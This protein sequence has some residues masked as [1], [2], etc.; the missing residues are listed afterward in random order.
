MADLFA[1]LRVTVRGLYRRP[2][3]TFTVLLTLALAIGANT[4]IFSLVN[5]LLIRSLPYPEASGL[6]TIYVRQTGGTVSDQRSGIDGQ[7]W[8][9]LRDNVPSLLSAVSGGMSDGVNVQMGGEARFLAGGRVSANYFNVLGIRPM[10]GRTFSQ[11]EDR[12]HG[13]N[14]ALLSY[15]VWHATFGGDPGVIGRPVLV[16]GEPYTVIGVLP[17]GAVTPLNAAVYT[18][19]RADRTG[20][21]QGTN[22]DA[23][24]RLKPHASWQEA[25]AE[26][27]RAWAP[28]RDRFSQTYPNATI[29]FHTVPLQQGQTAAVRPAALVLMTV[30][31]SI[32]LIACANL[33]GL[34]LVRVQQR[35]GEMATRMAL[36]A[37]RWQMQRQLWEENLLLALLGG[38]AGVG[39]GYLA[40]RGLLSMLPERFLPVTQVQLDW[41]VLAF[42]AVLALLTSV[43]FGMLPSLVLRRMDLRTAM[44]SRTLVSGGGLRLRQALIVGE[45]ALTFV[46]LAASGLLVRTLVHLETL[47]P[48]FNPQG[49]LSAKVSL[50]DARY[51][52]PAAFRLLLDQSLARMRQIPGVQSAAVALTLPYERALNDGVTLHDGKS[53]GQTVGTDEVYVTPG[54]FRTMQMNLLRGREFTEEDSPRSQPVVIVNQ[55]F[56]QKFFQ[57]EDAVGHTVSTRRIVGVVAD[58]LLSAGLTEGGAPLASEETIYVPAS[59]WTDA[60]L[61]AMVHVW[62]QPSWVVRTSDRSGTMPQQMEAALAGVDAN[63]PFSGF[64]SMPELMDK[65][66]AT[67]RIEVALLTV[68]A[69]LALLLSTIGI[70]ALVANVIAQRN[71]EIGIRLALGSTVGRVMLHVSRAGLVP[72]V[73]G[74][75]AGL[76]LCGL[77]LRAIRSAL[78]GVGAFDPAT[79]A[80]VVAL[81]LAVSACATAVPA[82]RAAKVDP[83]QTLREE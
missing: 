44:A 15:D 32:L 28:L 10:L 24:V 21:G 55:S 57:G 4:A 27:N 20:E 72:S 68:M 63:L 30:A 8:E 38:V 39:A 9:L 54:Y 49:V 53:A 62:F 14:V 59:Q 26:I 47:P 80:S 29:T 17:Q 35:T 11:D 12:L 78:Y 43:L 33:A 6:G 5:A 61:L 69:G 13:A 64:Y 58:T 41:R 45:V 34:M 71:R 70:F 75:L 16:K 42:T 31:G 40:L 25:D 48:G 50:D 46:L 51:R 52:D 73:T 3:F 82:M 23:I 60:K 37:S 1:S 22:F 36:G 56:A 18:P 19:L 7:R 67:Q 77:L 76:V 2:G 81:L 65:T 66:L 83:A 79:L 74:L